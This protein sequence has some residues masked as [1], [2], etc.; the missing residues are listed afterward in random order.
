MNIPKIAALYCRLSKHED[1]KIESNSIANQKITLLK[2]AQS[3]GYEHTQF[4]IDDGY[5]GTVFQRPALKDLEEAIQAGLVEAVIVK[6]VSRLGRDY[7]KVGHF[8]EHFF[9]MNSVRFIAVSGGIDSSTNST[10]F[11]PLYSVMDEWYARDISRKLKTMYQTR[12]TKG[13]PVGMPVYGYTRAQD[14]PK[15]WEPDPEAAVVVQRIFHLALRGFGIEQIASTLEQEKILT[16]THYRLSKGKKCA[17]RASPYPYRWAASTIAQILGRQEYC[18]DV[19]NLKTYSH[20]LRDNK[21]HMT[22]AENRSILK[23]VH[24]AIVERSIWEAVQQKRSREKNIRKARKPSLFSGFLRCGG[25]GSNLNYHFNQKNPSIEYYNCSNYVGNRG[26]CPNTHYV[27]LDYLEHCVL[28]EINALLLTVHNDWDNFVYTL[29]QQ[30]LS[31]IQLQEKVLTTEHKTI[32]KRQD[33]LASITVQLY[34][35]KVKGELDDETY[36]L[37][38]NKFKS[39]RSTN[40]QRLHLLQEEIQGNQ[41]ALDEVERFSETIA[42]HSQIGALTREVLQELVD[43]IVIYPAIRNGKEYTQNISIHYLHIGKIKPKSDFCT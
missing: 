6:D 23:N 19:V 18:G 26:T 14:N 38:S 17:G 41:S 27:R 43:Y 15:Y 29:E 5:S 12:V 35:D 28:D 3:Y 8:V 33:E 20:S 34:E 42:R 4:F 31:E 21:R 1:A 30:K 37:L 39:E 32:I 10:D 36:H 2:A 7:L 40:Q 13:E 22:S 25:C 11:L 16:P 24:E 9:P